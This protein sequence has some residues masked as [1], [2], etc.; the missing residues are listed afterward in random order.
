M[1]IR[2]YHGTTLLGS[3]TPEQ[4]AELERKRVA[5]QRRAGKLHLVAVEV[6][7]EAYKA[8]EINLEMLCRR[9]LSAA[10][11]QN[12][13]DKAT[14]AWIGHVALQAMRSQ[15]TRTPHKRATASALRRVAYELVEHARREWGAP[16]S[17]IGGKQ[18]ATVTAYQWAADALTQAGVKGA[19]AR[20]VERW[21]QEYPKQ[22]NLGGD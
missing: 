17:R 12:L 22:A 10:I 13:S 18:G 21:H 7:L 3:M 2:K 11:A 14:E 1:T 16:K 20:D 19:T 5:D 8:S 15:Q 9:T 4:E 6:W